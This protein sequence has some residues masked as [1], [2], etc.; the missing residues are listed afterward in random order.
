MSASRAW[1]RGRSPT[2][3]LLT[4]VLG[5]GVTLGFPI[6]I[7]GKSLHFS[8]PRAPSFHSGSH[9]ICLWGAGKWEAR[10]S[11]SV[12]SHHLTQSELLQ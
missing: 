12:P 7:L 10:S 3:S 5:V 4:S 9:E 2:H 11:P 8:E 6:L 1:Y